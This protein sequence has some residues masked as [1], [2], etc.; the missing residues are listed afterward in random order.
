MDITGDENECRNEC[1][2]GVEICGVEVLLPAAANGAVN[3]N[4]T[5]AVHTAHNG[6]ATVRTDVEKIDGVLVDGVV[7]VNVGGGAS[8]RND[9]DND[10][11]STNDNGDNGDSSNSNCVGSVA[12][13]VNC[14]TKINSDTISNGVGGNSSSSSSSNIKGTDDI[15]KDDKHDSNILTNSIS[16]TNN[17]STNKGSKIDPELEVEPEN[18]NMGVLRGI[19]QEIIEKSGLISLLDSHLR[20]E[21]FIEIENHSDLYYLIFQVTKTNKRTFDIGVLHFIFS[22]YFISL[23]FSSYISFFLLLFHLF[24]ISINFTS[25]Y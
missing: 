6:T 2:S 9:N 15:S 8:G 12:Q 11:V 19:L 7:S 5:V 3:V 4:D 14:N 17:G 16:S 22:F 18:E 24:F 1:D 13:R 25:F 21:S 20:N 10:S 23:I